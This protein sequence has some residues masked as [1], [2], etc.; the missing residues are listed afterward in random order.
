MLFN[1][2]NFLLF[3]PIVVLCYYI[4]PAR[5]RNLWLLLCSYYF[6]MNWNARYALL[7]GLST[8]ITYLSGL[9]IEWAKDRR[10]YRLFSLIFCFGSNLLILFFFKY[11]NFALS[12]LS[13]IL[14]VC[15]LSLSLPEWDIILPVGISFYTFQALSY[16][17]DVYKGRI[18][19]EH[20]PLR[21]ALFVSFFPQL[22][23]GPIERSE[24][25]LS[26]L[27][28][29]DH[30]TK[31]H[32]PFDYA[33]ARE[34]LFLMLLGYF[35]KMIIAERA[36]IIVDT[37]YDC[38][39]SY[40]GFALILATLLFA[41]QIYCDF[42]GYSHIAIGAAKVLGIDLMDNF[43]QP[44]FA[45]SIQDFWHRWHISLST[46]FRDYLY[47]PLGGNRKG[48]LRKYANLMITFLV[49][50]LWHGAGMHFIIWGGI[51]GLYQV[52]G[53]ITSKLRDSVK[54]FLH[55][56][57]Q[58]LADRTLK[59]IVTFFLVCIAWIFFRAG[60]IR[61]SI[62]I[63]VHSLQGLDLSFFTAKGFLNLGLDSRQ[64]VILIG[65]ILLLLFIDLLHERQRSLS[66]SLSKIPLIPRW[67][68]YFLMITPV[69]LQALASFGESASSFIYFQF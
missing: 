60:S 69:F 3:F 1:S 59:R 46:W 43:H 21:Y 8:L 42:G 16:T 68:L 51:H 2:F 5:F 9:M 49:S 32:P 27:Q 50:G 15:H 61:D 14:G 39:S 41:V 22:V 65:A 57:P 56:T 26:Q 62:Y 53:D 17:A 30:T 25:L 52:I 6:Y 13:R 23:A 64:F 58:G 45:T 40:E 31:K 63:M 4:I 20:N 35:E 54:R 28:S 55:I 7:L 38:A 47:I 37:I 48:K 12:I 24:R 11:F 18:K 10:A 44:Y 67:L 36:G 29:I 19:A 33:K 34:G 66:E